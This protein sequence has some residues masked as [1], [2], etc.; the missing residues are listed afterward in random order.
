MS[1]PG[2]VEHG[3]HVRPNILGHKQA[4]AHLSPYVQFALPHHLDGPRLGAARHKHL[5]GNVSTCSR[6]FV[7]L[8]VAAGISLFGDHVLVQRGG[9]SVDSPGAL[10]FL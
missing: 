9:D 4:R 8:R 6:F 1:S 7:P 10:R 3:R 5:P 2:R